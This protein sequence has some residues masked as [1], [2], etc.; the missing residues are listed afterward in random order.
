M[1]T[2]LVTCLYVGASVTRSSS[3][4]TARCPL[5]LQHVSPCSQN[6]TETAIQFGIAVTCDLGSRCTRRLLLAVFVTR[7]Q[8]RVSPQHPQM[9]LRS[10]KYHNALYYTCRKLREWP[11]PDSA[12]SRT[13][14]DCAIW[15]GMEQGVLCA[16]RT[17]TACT[18]GV[19]QYT[20]HLAGQQKMLN[21]NM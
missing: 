20:L 4:C 14:T 10:C 17:N 13:Q 18:V 15:V 21:G 11:T 12:S 7:S 8:W 3:N 5:V 16:T 6:C 2:R 9:G 1:S 19:F